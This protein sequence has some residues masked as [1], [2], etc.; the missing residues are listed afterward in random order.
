VKAKRTTY[1]GRE[2]TM[3]T[4]DTQTDWDWVEQSHMDLALTTSDDSKCF[5]T[6]LYFRYSPHCDHTAISPKK[7]AQLVLN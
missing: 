4:L 3:V 5:S 2:I 1:D 6:E 7:G